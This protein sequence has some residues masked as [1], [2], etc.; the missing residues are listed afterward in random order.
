MFSCPIFNAFGAVESVW[1]EISTLVEEVPAAFAPN[2]VV[3]RKAKA[4]KAVGDDWSCS[5]TGYSFEVTGAVERQRKPSQFLLMF[6]LW[7]PPIASSWLAGQEALLTFAYAPRLDEGWDASQ[8]AIGMDG[9][10]LDQESRDACRL[11]AGDRL[12]EWPEEEG[13]WDRRAWLF[14]VP[15]M[16]LDGPAA[17]LREVVTPVTSIIKGK[18]AP[19]TELQGLGA[20]IFPAQQEE[21]EI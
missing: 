3:T 12:L 14:S 18:A 15:L 20:L 9:L 13:S 6:D 16:R 10:L 7:R 2:F 17:F 8:V 21:P 11:E 19:A 4:E 5:R 1:T